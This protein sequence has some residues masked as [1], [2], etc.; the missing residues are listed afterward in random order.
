[1]TSSVVVPA[2]TPDDALTYVQAHCPESL[3]GTAVQRIYP[4]KHVIVNWPLGECDIIEQEL[5][6][7]IVSKM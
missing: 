6:K 7:A 1:M 2:N 5:S 4:V 3:N